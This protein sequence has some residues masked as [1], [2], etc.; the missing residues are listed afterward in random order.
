MIKAKLNCV[1]AT[2]AAALLI[3]FAGQPALAQ[4][5][6]DDTP[7]VA[8]GDNAPKE[9]E[10][11]DEKAPVPAK[12][13]AAINY[14]VNADPDNIWVLDLSNGQRVK[15]RLMPD[16]APGHVERIKELSRRGFYNGVI[17]HRVIDGFM[18]QGGD[19]TGTGQGG[20]ELPDLKA[21]FN[22][23]PHVRGTLSMARAS[24][25]DSANSQFFIV[26]YPRF[27]LDKKYT[28]FGRVIENMEAVD[29][30]NKGEPPAQPTFITQASLA[31]DNLPPP[32]PLPAAEEAPISADMLSAP[33]P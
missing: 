24:E 12:V 10:D 9:D 8:F 7:P 15:I 4:K 2:L 22:P 18:A 16:W 29:A 30:I 6:K 14:D 25:E 13:Y 11:E 1:P 26:F 33:I 21:E 17:F 20:S 31:S 3:A 27:S 19:P 23:M 5:Q 32:P 28:N